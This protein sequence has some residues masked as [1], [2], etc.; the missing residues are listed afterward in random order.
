MQ[1]CILK[2]LSK[3][4]KSLKDDQVLNSCL[5]LFSNLLFGG[6]ENGNMERYKRL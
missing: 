5:F 1:Q 6:K 4:G 2:H 3:R